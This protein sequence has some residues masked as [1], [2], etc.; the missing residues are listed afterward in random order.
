MPIALLLANVFP[1]FYHAL[2]DFTLWEHAPIGHLHD[3]HRSLT[4]HFLVND[5]LMALFFAVAGKEIWEAIA[6][7]NGSLR[8]KTALTPLFATAGG[9]AGPIL[10]YLGIAY[11][12]GQGI[13]EAVS[14][15]WAIPTATDIVFSAMI[16]RMI[17]G[18]RHPAVTF[19]LLLAVADDAGGLIILAVFYPTD[20]VAPLWLLMSFGTCLLIWFT[21]NWLPRQTQATW[22]QRLGVWPYVIG[23]LIS[24]YGFQMAGIHPALGLLPIIPA[25]PH[26][27]HDHGLY[28]V[29]ENTKT[30]MLN[31]LEHL[32]VWPMPLIMLL[33]GL[34]NAGVELSTIGATTG[35]VLAGLVIGKP[36]GIFLLGYLGALF[37]G[38]PTGMTKRHLLVLGSVAGIG[39]TVALFVS[40]VALPS[41]PLQDGAKLGALLS[42][43]SAIPAF[44]LAKILHIKKQV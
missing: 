24:W 13:F 44:L 41:G 2:V 22:C 21:C 4:V 38:L 20:V 10:V 39:F 33:F 9:M 15:G 17:F 1:D 34:V 16:G 42:L 32:V 30:D 36:I 19:L 7:P 25:I 27:G 26:A 40:G 18:E 23:G 35:L 6:L 37:F 5:I 28:S 14:S 11:V 3:G 31:R 29:K 8:G 43:F 12:L